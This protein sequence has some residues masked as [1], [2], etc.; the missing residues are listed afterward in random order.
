MS[1]QRPSK[2]VPGATGRLATRIADDSGA[3]KPALNGKELQCVEYLVAMESKMVEC[4][5]ALRDRLKLV[6]HGWRQYRLLAST[7]DRLLRDLYPTIPLKGQ[8]Y[9][10]KSMKHGEVLIRFVPTYRPPEWKMVKDEDL[11]TLINLAMT[12]ECAICLKS[13]REIKKCELRRALEDIAPPDAGHPAGGCG[14]NEVTLA[15]EYG[16]YVRRDGT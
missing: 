1:R 5:D 9:L 12:A 15:G 7:L 11:A 4:G 2:V 6:P 10:E 16:K 8:L 3:D 13:G 14:Y